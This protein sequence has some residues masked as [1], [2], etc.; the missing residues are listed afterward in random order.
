MSITETQHADLTALL[1][2]VEASTAAGKP[3]KWSDFHAR[4]GAI[5][6]GDG[7]ALIDGIRAG[8]VKL[9]A[10][11]NVRTLKNGTTVQTF[12]TGGRSHTAGRH[13]PASV[14]VAADNLK[15]GETKTLASGITVKR[16][17]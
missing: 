4:A 16:V 12:P 14:P 7:K 9:A 1:N 15:A 17:K 8:T 6:N 10:A 5:I 2:E 3:V 11:S 13:V